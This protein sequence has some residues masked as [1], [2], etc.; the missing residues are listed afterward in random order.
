MPSYSGD[1]QSYLAG[2][3][4]DLLT[5]FPEQREKLERY[6]NAVNYEYDKKWLRKVLP[7]NAHISC[8]P[9]DKYTGRYSVRFMLRTGTNAAPLIRF[10]MDL[11]PECCALFQLNGFAHALS[12]YLD[13]GF[14]REFVEKCMRA[15]RNV[16]GSPPR[17]MINF[18]EDGPYAD[19][20]NVTPT[21]AEPLKV[22]FP[23][24]YDWA[25]QYPMQVNRF[26]NHNTGRVIRNVV[27]NYR[28]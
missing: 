26:V 11:Y 1:C 4:E 16:I 23:M 10:T 3:V 12:T 15:Y 17:I 2:A 5:R 8:E 19:D 18:V 13:E 28:G 7:M 27:I 6:N 9:D 21:E 14:F 24:W 20:H 25:K 22:I